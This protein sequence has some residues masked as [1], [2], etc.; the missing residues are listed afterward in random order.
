MPYGIP[1][2]T[3]HTGIP[4]LKQCGIILTENMTKGSQH[5]KKSSL[6]TSP[7][8]VKTTSLLASGC[9]EG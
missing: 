2:H 3:K 9:A 4:L 7:E 6:K 8:N 5:P 1:L